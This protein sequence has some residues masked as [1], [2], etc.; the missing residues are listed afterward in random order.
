M[1]EG[2]GSGRGGNG[3]G[4]GAGG[5][6][7][8]AKAKASASNNAGAGGAAVAAPSVAKQAPT[9][10]DSGR[11]IT[12]ATTQLKRVTVSTV[13]PEA[14]KRLISS[15]IDAAQQSEQSATQSKK[16]KNKKKKRASV[17]SA[18]VEAVA[19]PVPVVAPPKTEPAV[20]VAEASTESPPA[21]TKKARK[22]KHK[23]S[24]AAAAK[25]EEEKESSASEQPTELVTSQASA[26]KAETA[27]VVEPE[28]KQT[29]ETAAPKPLKKIVVL[30][31]KTAG[32]SSLSQAGTSAQV[33]P[34]SR[35]T[36]A[37]PRN[38]VVEVK[39]APDA[40]QEPTPKRATAAV[41][42]VSSTEN[43]STPTKPQS[44]AVKHNK[45]KTPSSAAS[46]EK[47]N[48][49]HVGD[50]LPTPDSKF[51]KLP[52]SE[53][54][55]PA[56]KTVASPT[57]DRHS[58][59][60]IS[61]RVTS[62][63]NEKKPSSPIKIIE[64]VNAQTNDAAHT[65]VSLSSNTPETEETR[66]I[67][68]DALVQLIDAEEAMLGTQNNLDILAEAV[69]VQ[70]TFTEEIEEDV[71]GE[72]QSDSSDFFSRMTAEEANSS[73]PDLL[74]LME[75]GNDIAPA[76]VLADTPQDIVQDPLTGLDILSQVTSG[77]P[78]AQ[79][80]VS[81]SESSVPAEA[82]VHESLQPQCVDPQPVPVEQSPPSNVSFTVDEEMKTND[83]KVAVHGEESRLPTTRKFN[84]LQLTPL[85]NFVESPEPART[86]KRSWETAWGASFGLTDAG[87][88]ENDTQNA[89][90]ASTP[91]SSWFF[92]KGPANFKK[93]VVI[94]RDREVKSLMHAVPGSPRARIMSPASKH[95]QN[96]TT[97]ATEEESGLSSFERFVQGLVAK[98]AWRSCYVSLDANDLLD[99]PLSPS[100]LK[101][102]GAHS[103]R[104][105]ET[106]SN[107][108]DLGARQ[109]ES[110]RVAKK[111]SSSLAQLEEQIREE[112]KRAKAF[113]ETLL[114]ALQGKTLSGKEV[115]EEY[116]HMLTPK[117]N[118][119]L[120]QQKVARAQFLLKGMQ[121]RD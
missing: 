111:R 103:S 70:P 99:P 102:F 82:A 6:K 47:P 3:A 23:K 44:K 26:Q 5:R 94:P 50:N 67:D 39:P 90:S 71:E 75:E 25:A 12:R 11:V 48:V 91:L 92:S 13:V 72:Q 113:D 118:S 110:P 55:G 27:K 32:A 109:E 15:A 17:T 14:T 100:L 38:K 73:I 33:S 58:P 61:P 97:R 37:S 106:E 116:G 57:E 59:S 117:N 51:S 24:G 83:L 28:K 93:R 114:Q 42:S 119:C 89:P 40:Q 62:T 1:T 56:D 86:R 66:G 77:I 52:K 2:R 20:S 19:A 34:V 85:V 68:T 31:K 101:R 74:R 120:H 84:L 35:V 41:P 22:R 112:R 78:A 16:K 18:S 95:P 46:G 21:R 43:M 8:K 10:T 108:F 7:G 63:S 29:P 115:T 45:I 88:A 104:S 54:V 53:D 107:S 9:S 87:S 69:P 64:E 65:A 96:T 76:D 98:S 105:L 49:T 79:P 36:T 80:I 81:I 121:Y 60:P 4:R 30:N